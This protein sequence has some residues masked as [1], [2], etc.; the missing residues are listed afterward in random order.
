[1]AKVGQKR[2]N[3]EFGKFVVEKME[4]KQILGY[5]RFDRYFI[6]R[7]TRR[8]VQMR[9]LEVLD[10]VAGLACSSVRLP[11]AVVVVVVVD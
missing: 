6:S 5:G 2:R 1:M 9:I 8:V 7:A 3:G 11:G 4:F 10:I